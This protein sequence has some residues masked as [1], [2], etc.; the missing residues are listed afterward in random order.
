MARKK[1]KEKI[2]A[3]LFVKGG[4]AQNKIAERL[5]VSE[6]TVSRWKREGNWESQRAAR[7]AT[8]KNL[9]IDLQQNIY[10]ISQQANIED[11][12]LTQGEADKIA[13]LSAAIERIE[14]RTTLSDVIGV[15]EDFMNY[16]SE[17]DLDLAKVVA[18]H[19]NDFVI[20]RAREYG[21]DV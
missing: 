11:R 18:P 14:K 21:H 20:K 5:G 7:V 2:A 16:I 19:Q 17:A 13:K 9:V 12:A 10:H 4:L 1:D 3:D 8:P 15:M 6:N